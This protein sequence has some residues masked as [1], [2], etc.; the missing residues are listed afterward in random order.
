MVRQF[1]LDRRTELTV[2][3]CQRF[4]VWNPP[5]A[6]VRTSIISVPGC[7]AK[8][9]MRHSNFRHFC[10]SF[11]CNQCPVRMHW[12]VSASETTHL[13]KKQNKTQNR[14]SRTCKSMIERVNMCSK[15][16]FPIIS[17]NTF[18][19][20]YSSLIKVAKKIFFGKKHKNTYFSDNLRKTSLLFNFV[21]LALLRL[22]S[23]TP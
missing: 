16:N 12:G 14:V 19:K 6:K 9:D 3:Y 17:E 20:R 15:Q 8:W 23:K 21:C 22:T 1:W 10:Q 4:H 18:L 2:T 5:S 13:S 11:I 7:I